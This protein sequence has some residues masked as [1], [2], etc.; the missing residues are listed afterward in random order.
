MNATDLMPKQSPSR[1][2]LRCF[3]LAPLLILCANEAHAIAQTVLG[4]RD[5]SVSQTVISLNQQDPVLISRTLV[6]GNSVSSASA[7]LSSGILR[8]SGS[9]ALPTS[10]FTPSTLT[11][12]SSKALISD[13]F[14]FS[15]GASGNANFDWH[16]SGTI[17]TNPNKFGEGPYSQAFL[18]I[19]FFPRLGGNTISFESA[20]TNGINCPA[21]T[22]LCTVG[23]S[24]NR[25]GSIS[26]P[27][28][29]GGYS[30]SAILSVVARHGDVVRFDNTANFYMQVPDGVSVLSNSG[31]FLAS[32]APIVAVP[33][34]T[35]F[36]LSLLGLLLVYSHL[37]FNRSTCMRSKT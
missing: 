3:I 17:E 14:S 18:D 9:S 19:T 35:T 12:A 37:V 24:V 7:D 4:A 11:S 16:F 25:S 29:Q 15:A 1:A 21:I 8:A 31:V 5:P 22:T 26:L 13:A 10:A 27:M 32:A 6:Q 23:A 2:I 28:I 20:L 33:E 30:M 36:V 34:P